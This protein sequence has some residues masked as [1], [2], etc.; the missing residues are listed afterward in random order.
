MWHYWGTSGDFVENYLGIRVE[1]VRTRVALLG[2]LWV[3]RG[4]LL[5]NSSGSSANS[6]G[7]I[8]E[9]MGTPWDIIGEFVFK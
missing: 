5:G 3:L 1:V 2:N 6:C 7:I 9:L 4:Q 8:G